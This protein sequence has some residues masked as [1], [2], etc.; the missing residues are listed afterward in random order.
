MRTNPEQQ[1]QGWVFI[2]LLVMLWVA[3]KFRRQWRGQGKAF[4]T[5]K[6]CNR[7]MM[8][9]A[10]MLSGPGLVFGRTL[11]RRELIRIRD[12]CHTL[13][14]GGTGS[15][16]GRG[17]IGPNLLWY[18]KPCVVFDT[19]SDLYKMS[20]SRRRK[21][22][23]RIVCLAPFGDSPDKLNPLDSI[24]IGPLMVD[25]GRAL[26]ESLVVRQGTEPDQ[27]WN[28]SAVMVICAA[29][30]FVLYAMSPEHRNLNSVKDIISDPKMLDEVAI[31]LCA[32]DG[33]MARMGSQVQGLQDKER[34]SILSTACR[35]LSFLDSEKVGDSLADSTFDPA[36]IVDGIDVYI[37]IPPNMLL[38]HSG[39]LRCWVQTLVNGVCANEYRAGREVLF[40]LDEA[41]ALHNL[42][43]LEE[44]LVR[45]R[46]AGARLLLAYQSDSQVK[47]AFKDK[48][49]LLYDNCSTTIYLGASSL[50]TAERISQMCG[51][52]TITVESANYGTSSSRS[53]G[54]HK[55]HEGQLSYSQG[56]NWQEQARPLLTAS[57]ILA[58][59]TNLLLAF[60]QGM[61]PILARK[62][63]WDQEATFNT[64]L[65]PRSF[66]KWLAVASLIILIRVFLIH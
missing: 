51:N 34:S 7:A 37:Q 30:V 49:S 19:K 23:H 62:I 45:G 64:S 8:Q 16:K 54:H 33:V 3:Y 18:P 12:F 17:I 44:V 41:S 29:I 35:H 42:P 53:T 10:K 21:M 22:G 6:F 60:V 56:W 11:Q 58:L 32:M 20:S 1:L 52:Q 48:P 61:H 50:E 38:S 36:K 27:H 59:N 46:S 31:R 24:P 28:D 4:G 47:A 14:I 26:A 55:P 57:E 63:K 40:V 2:L 65:R 39:L 5:A 9:M 13:I 66:L 25:Q 43:G 15:G